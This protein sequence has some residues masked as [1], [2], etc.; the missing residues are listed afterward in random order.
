MKKEL[1]F[2]RS[3]EQK[4]VNDMAKY[5]YPQNMD[6]I[7]TY[8]EF[9]GLTTKDLGLYALVD[10]KIAGAIWSREIDGVPKLSVA[11]LREFKSQGIGLF[12]ME[13]FLQEA[14]ALY[15]IITIDISHK[16]ASIKFY[17]K[18]GFQKL[19]NYILTKKLELKE[20]VRPTDG[21]DP[22]KWIQ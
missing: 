2:L 7:N 1:Y 21:Y 18:F 3:S 19:D 17:E 11:I 15:E 9:Y 5:A 13:Q 6:N 16:P 22:T 8:T 10:N 14:A 4:I 20:V 12:M